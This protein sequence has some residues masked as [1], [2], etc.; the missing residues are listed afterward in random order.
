MKHKLTIGVSKESPKDSVVTYKKVSPDAKVKDLFG[1][2]NKVAIIVPGDSVK[3]VTIEE[4]KE[5]GSWLNFKDIE[6]KD[7]FKIEDLRGC[8]AIGGVDLSSTTD[9][10]CAVLYV[11]KDGKKYLVSHFFMPSDVLQERIQEDSV[12]YDIW[13]QKGYITLTDGSQNDFSLVTQWFRSMI[14]DYDIR[15]LWVGYDPWNSQYWVKEMEDMGFEMEKIRQ[16]V[17]TLSEHMKQL[18]AD[19]RNHALNY[20]NNPIIKWCLTNTQAKVEVNGNIQPSKLNSR[21]K[22]IDGT[23]ATIIAYATL[24]RYKIDYESMAKQ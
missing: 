18:E 15:P 21:L 10:T 8:Y 11:E 6:N 4:S 12:P 17:Y 14:D 23:V 1:A 2:T 13:V 16:G 7:T 20:D 3:S 22:R 9:L 5:D 24:N 19:I